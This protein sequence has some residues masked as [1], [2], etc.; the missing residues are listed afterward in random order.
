MQV[1]ITT[2]ISTTVKS[3]QSKKCRMLIKVRTGEMHPKVANAIRNVDPMLADV[4]TE[5]DIQNAFEG[6]KPTRGGGKG[7]IKISVEI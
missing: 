5:A 3:A 1:Q 2:G 6:N 7:G 4:M